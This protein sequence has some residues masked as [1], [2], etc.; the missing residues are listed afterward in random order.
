VAITDANFI[1]SR[2]IMEELFKLVSV[3]REIKTAADDIIKKFNPVL[4][5]L[6]DSNNE[7]VQQ[8]IKKYPNHGSTIQ[9]SMR[10][11]VNEWMVEALRTRAE[12]DSV[13]ITA[14]G[15]DG[16]V[17]EFN[18]RVPFLMEVYNG[19]IY[20]KQGLNGVIALRDDLKLQFTDYSR[21]KLFAT[22]TERLA[23]VI[24]GDSKSK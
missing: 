9:E 8:A 20:D 11:V 3:L 22:A 23:T 19:D 15:D 18:E 14:P 1:L 13:I 21:A 12:L 7:L 2:L 5:N 24:A 17:I 4:E 6:K 16:F 10:K